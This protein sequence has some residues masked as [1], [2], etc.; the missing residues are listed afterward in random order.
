MGDGEE[1]DD[2]EEYHHI[3]SCETEHQGESGGFV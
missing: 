2:E 1:R 3:E